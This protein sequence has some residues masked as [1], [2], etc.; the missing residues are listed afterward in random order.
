MPG[1]R[2]DPPSS[3]ERGRS[4]GAGVGAKLPRMGW[5]AY[6]QVLRDAPLTDDEVRAVADL[7]RTERKRPW[8]AES[9]SLRIARERRGDRVVASG[10]N[11]LAGDDPAR[12]ASALGRLHELLGGELRA[13]DDFG[14]LPRG[15]PLVDVRDEDLVAPETLAPAS[16]TVPH[17][18]GADV[19]Q[20]IDALAAADAAAVKTALGEKLAAH[21]AAAIATA[22]YRRYA[23]IGHHSHLRAALG[24]ALRRLDRPAAI[25]DAFLAAWRAPKGTYFYG[26]MPLPDGFADAIVEVPAVHAQLAAD[27]VGAE[28]AGDNELALRCA[29][30][31]CG[32]LAR[33]ATGRRTLISTIRALRG[34]SLTWR[35]ELYMFVPAH[36]ALAERGDASVVP[37]LLRYAGSAKRFNRFVMEGLVRLAPERMRA[38]VL[39]IAE[40]GG[41]RSETI[42]LLR[43]LGGADA[44]IARL[45]AR[46]EAPLEQRLVDPDRELRHGALKELVKRKD[47][48]T[49][50]TLVLA[51]ALDKYLRARTEDPS[52]PFG[53]YEWKELIP[54]DI[55]RESTAKKLQWMSAVGKNLLPPQDVW[56]CVAKILE[57]GPGAVEATYPVQELVLDAATL[58]ALE[59]EEGAQLT[60]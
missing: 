38:H 2:I 4:I 1:Q 19:D 58:A 46:K 22:I 29:E 49:F 35:V 47:P 20:L 16:A 32:L 42:S 23:S 59:A 37:T 40:A 41:H 33:T 15:A 6:Y 53:W 45:V 24:D 9:F 52:S 17:V 48:A 50:V 28:Q 13:S 54:E 30:R 8:E 10:W 60:A 12:L 36:R 14:V 34:K 43:T 51:E 11:K 25:A 7:V 21:E 39:A 5:T 57:V 26:D 56:P 3:G 55:G 31:A 18:D 44:L 27:V